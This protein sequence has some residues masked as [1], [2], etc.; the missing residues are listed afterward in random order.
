MIFDVAATPREVWA[1]LN[2]FPGYPEWIKDVEHT[3]TY[4]SDD[5]GVYVRFQ[6][7]TPFG[8]SW[9]WFARHV[10]PASAAAPADAIGTW[11]LD[12]QY[13]SSFRD[14]YGYWQVAA[15]DGEAGKTRVTYASN[16][17]L[18]GVTALFRGFV[19]RNMIKEGPAWL[20]RALAPP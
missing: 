12:H 15:V 2:A 8:T 18:R 13:R 20:R 9:T 17:R 7:R 5:S 11:E 10:Y 19:L 14:A 6:A 4:R 16:I 1:V 3:E